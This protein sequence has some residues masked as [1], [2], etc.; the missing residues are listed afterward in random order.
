MYLKGLGGLALPSRLFA[1]F[2]ALLLLPH[3]LSAE[4][5]KSEKS[6]IATKASGHFATHGA[7]LPTREFTD[8]LHAASVDI[9]HHC[10]RRSLAFLAMANEEALRDTVPVF[11][12]SL[13]RVKL[14]GGS[15]AGQRLDSK[16]VLVVWSDAALA[17]CQQLQRRYSHQCVQD[18][19]HDTQGGVLGYRSDDF[20]TLG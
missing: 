20:M 10:C 19:D 3:L 17:L 9:S 12:A 13:A 11:L 6:Y 8:A 5:V 16:L 18:R 2:L 14:E 7:N 4:T 15:Q 1:N